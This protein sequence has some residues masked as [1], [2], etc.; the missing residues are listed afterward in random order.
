MFYQFVYSATRPFIPVNMGVLDTAGPTKAQQLTSINQYLYRAVFPA[1]FTTTG[2]GA[3]LQLS[4]TIVFFNGGQYREM[5]KQRD[6]SR[7]N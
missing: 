2:V 5:H 7:S 4:S 3:V 6:V 1:A